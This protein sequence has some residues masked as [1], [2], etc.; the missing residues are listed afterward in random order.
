MELTLRHMAMLCAIEENGSITRAASRLGMSQPAL[1]AQLRR[2]ED[3]LGEQVFTRSGSGVTVTRSGRRV[4]THARTAQAAMSRLREAPSSLPAGPQVIRIGGGGPLLIALID[5]LDKAI[6]SAAVPATVMARAE[7][8]S[9]LIQAELEQ[10]KLDYAVLREYPGHE[11][12]RPSHT[13]EWE[14]VA[15]EPLFVGLARAHPLARQ[16]V[17]D[18]TQL[19][20]EAWAVDPDDDSGET[21]LLREACVAARFEPRMGLI[22]SDNGMIRSYIGSGRALGLFEARAQQDHEFVV[23]PLHGDPVHCRIVL[24]WSTDQRGLAIPSEQVS[25]TLTAA[26]EEASSNHPVYR[27]WLARQGV[28]KSPTS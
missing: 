10:G 13:A 22:S 4:L 23:R 28:A 12:P 5:R 9:R 11:V 2:I 7:R 17:I 8:S 1:T 25:E 27:E 15:D 21:E 14:L 24:R 3:E 26:Y 19:R 18:L 6:R 20:D 16:S